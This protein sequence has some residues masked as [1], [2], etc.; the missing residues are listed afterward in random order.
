MLQASDQCSELLALPFA[1]TPLLKTAFA[2]VEMDV[3]LACMDMQSLPPAPNLS[4][5]RVLTF[6]LD[7]ASVR[8]LAGPRIADAIL[9]RVGNSAQ[10]RPAQL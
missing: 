1:L 5:D 9:T 3:Q 2:G 7:E 6:C 4:D 10:D 8:G